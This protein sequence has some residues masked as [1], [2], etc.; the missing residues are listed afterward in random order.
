MKIKIICLEDEKNIK[1]NNISSKF[2]ILGDN[3]FKKRA[4]YYKVEKNIVE[5]YYLTEKEDINKYNLNSNSDIILVLAKSL[6]E[7]N[8][9]IIKEIRSNYNIIVAIGEVNIANKKIKEEFNKLNNVIIINKLK[10]ENIIDLNL[11][12][13][14]LNNKKM[15]LNLNKQ[16]NTILIDSNES[17]GKIVLSILDQFN[18]IENSKEFDLYLY[19]KEQVGIK[20]LTYLEDPIKEYI[21][22]DAILRVNTVINENIND[23]NYFLVVKAK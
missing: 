2:E 17:I 14:I 6:N 1:F 9:E 21:H 4:K 11:L 22:N 16:K 18:Y 10:K 12:L 7:K 13:I 19:S 23:K 15:F 20:E 3:S 5:I 8:I